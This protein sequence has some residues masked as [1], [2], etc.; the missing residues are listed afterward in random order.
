MR[1]KSA[2]S[3]IARKGKFIAIYEEI[4]DSTAYK[5]LSHTARALLIELYRME[6]PNRNGMIGL[7]EISAGKKLSCAS[8]TASKA[9][10]DL[11]DKGFIERM[12]DGDYTRGKASE[13]RLTFLPYRGM[14]PTDEW[15]LFKK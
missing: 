6:F 4:L 8:N 12:F 3:Y 2:I 14:E 9:F 1:K 13:W 7:S 11:I 5:A 10:E 15:K